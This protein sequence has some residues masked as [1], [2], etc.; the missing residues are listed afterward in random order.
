MN[1]KQEIENFINFAYSDEKEREQQLKVLEVYAKEN[2]EEFRLREMESEA[3]G[4]SW[5]EC[6]ENMD[7]EWQQEYDELMENN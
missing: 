7:E 6:Y 5:T 1:L 4:I 3:C 2:K